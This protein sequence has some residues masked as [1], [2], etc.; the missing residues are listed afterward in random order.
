MKQ[1]SLNFQPASESTPIPQIIAEP[2]SDCINL[3]SA[4]SDDESITPATLSEHEKHSDDLEE[5]EFELVE[6]W[7]QRQEVTVAGG[8][9]TL[10]VELELDAYAGAMDIDNREQDMGDGNEGEDE[11]GDQVDNGLECEPDMTREGS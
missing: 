6:D 10:A 8:I 2:Q 5:A 7:I 1:S 11:G 4:S 9:G 3:I